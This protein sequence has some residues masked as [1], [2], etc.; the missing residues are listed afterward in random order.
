MS[1]GKYLPGPDTGT[2]HHVPGGVTRPRA[3]GCGDRGVY[4]GLAEAM[5]KIDEARSQVASALQEFE[6]VAQ[7]L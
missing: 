4:W 6:G 2:S 7:R 5:N 3:R 1:R